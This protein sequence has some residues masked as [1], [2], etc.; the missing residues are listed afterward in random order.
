MFQNR[1]IRN[2]RQPAQ[3]PY[4]VLSWGL[5]GEGIWNLGIL[6]KPENL[7]N[8]VGNPIGAL[9]LSGIK[10]RVENCVRNPIPNP[11]MY[12]EPRTMCPEHSVWNPIGTSNLVPLISC[13]LSPSIGLLC[14]SPRPE[15]GLILLAFGVWMVH[16]GEHAAST[17]LLKSMQ[18]DANRNPKPEA[19]ET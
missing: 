17:V 10:N 6:S 16:E 7:S 8:L 4:R 9:N 11:A 1:K 3:E 19:Q 15:V 12:Q 5:V 18:L 13:R 2:H 14:S